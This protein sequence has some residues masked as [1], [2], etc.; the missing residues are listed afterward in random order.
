MVFV[1]AF[2]QSREPISFRV[3]AIL[4]RRVVTKFC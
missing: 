3:L 4:D 2:L 1:T